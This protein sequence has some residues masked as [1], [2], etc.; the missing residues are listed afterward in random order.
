MGSVAGRP[1]R[2]LS[3]RFDSALPTGRRGPD[4]RFHFVLRII[5]Q[6]KGNYPVRAVREDSPGILGKEASGRFDS[7]LP[8]NMTSILIDIET[9]SDVDLAACGLYRYAESDA[10]RVLLFGYSVDGGPAV[11]ADLD[12]GEELPAH[13]LEALWDPAVKKLAHNMAFEIACL[14]RH[15]G[16]PLDESQWWDTMALGA[17]LG[18][19]LSL[20]QLGEVLGMPQDKQKM[21]EGKSLVS[22]FCKPYKGERRMPGKH[23]EKWELFKRYCQRDVDSEV[24]IGARL[25]RCARQP[26]WEREV[27]LLDFRINKRGV[28]V[29]A[30]LAGNALR[31]W[32]RCSAEL[33]E[34]ARRITG[35]ENPNSVAQL[36]PWLARWGVRTE[37]LDKATVRGIL[38]NPYR[39]ECVRRMLEIRLDLGKTSVRKYE[40]MLQWRCR[41]GRAHGL[42]QYYGTFTGRFSGRGVQMQN[43]PQN[44]L[45]D[46]GQAR[47]L[48][49][50]GDYEMFA[51]SYASVP[52]TLSQLIRTA[53]VPSAGGV[54]H[55][56]DFSAIEARVTAWVSGERWV[57]DTFAS[58]GDIYCVTASRM[59]G[60]EVT[61]HGPHGALRQP[62]KVAVLACGYGGGPAAFDAMAR[63][64]GL[65]FTDQEK[66]TYVRQWRRANPHTVALWGVVERAAVA[67]VETGRVI[68]V[69]RGI[70]MQRQYGMLMVTLPSGRR[71]AY[72]RVR[73]TETCKGTRI[74]YERLGQTTKKW[75]T[76]DTWGGKLVENIVQAIARDILCHVMLKAEAR[77]HR[78]VFH[79]HDEIIVDS[80]RPDALPE[81]EA[82]FA[83]PIAWCP[84]LP[85]KGA[86]YTTPYYMKD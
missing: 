52:D 10:F 37:S 23:R 69:N 45:G 43:L 73:V 53:F 6:S 36:K 21:R 44:H 64:Y 84:G 81:I 48:L 19:P 57:L 2:G 71:I 15:F 42:T 33:V 17:Y 9:Y 79:V 83:E 55:V 74:T 12:A 28:A 39:P 13:V 50:S 47:A 16:K 61:K 75:E 70:L 80:P 77:G 59:F 85:L 24:A 60:V 35:L 27:Q 72:P 58:G 22:F 26:R 41:D 78:I 67:A 18:L 40:T 49:R 11:V 54:L 62:G 5:I 86:G 20:G 34:E 14:G 30:V 8:R 4:F 82:L 31:F 68:A 38:G 3:G 76:A 25:A 66:E 65:T 32:E 46:L 7:A 1:P 63:N 51:L 29:D 56:C